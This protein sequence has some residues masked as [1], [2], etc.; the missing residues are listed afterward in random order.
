[1]APGPLVDRPC[2]KH[3]DAIFETPYAAITDFR[4]LAQAAASFLAGK[5]NTIDVLVNNAGIGSIPTGRIPTVGYV[6][7]GHCRD[8]GVA[9]GLLAF[10]TGQEIVV[11]G[12]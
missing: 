9:H 2:T 6:R 10:V 11:D 1:M 12:A 8:G 5:Q 4:T 7:R 3:L